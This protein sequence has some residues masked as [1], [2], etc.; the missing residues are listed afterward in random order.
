MKLEPDHDDVHAAAK[1]GDTDEVAALLSMDNR[2]T[3]TFDT[4]GWTPLHLAAHYGHASTV[5][6]LLHNNAPVD[7]R[8]QNQ[9]ANTAL[10]AALAGQR[11]A[12]RAQVARLLVDGG[13]DVNAVQHGGWTPIHQ[14]AANGDRE[15]AELLIARG[16]QRDVANDAGV[17]PAAIAHQRGHDAIATWLEGKR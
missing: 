17:T 3:R 9:L 4:D 7:L 8:S 13:A 1:A 15:T 11:P 6:I 12:E 10:H 2:L 5:E 14:A 16:A